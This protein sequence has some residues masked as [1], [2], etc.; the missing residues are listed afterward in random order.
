MFTAQVVKLI[1]LHLQRLSDDTFRPEIAAIARSI[2]H[3]STTDIELMGDPSDDR[4][5]PTHSPDASFICRGAGY[6]CVVIE[7]SFSQKRKDLP[8][9]AEDYI[10]GSCGNIRLVVGLDIE[11]RSSKRATVSVWESQEG[12]DE[13]GV[14]YLCAIKIVNDEV[15]FLVLASISAAVL[16][17][18]PLK[19]FR[20]DDSSPVMSNAALTLPL[21]AFT[22]PGTTLVRSLKDIV[23]SI[24]YRD[25]CSYLEDAERCQK[26]TKGP[27]RSDAMKMLQPGTR[28]R[29]S[30][31]TPESCFKPP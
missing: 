28:L 14:P 26:D 27:A 7:T 11:Y 31:R 24:P 30:Q 15:R 16:T 23:V 5:Y 2:A 6:P 19:L 3:L 29:R 12:F 13:D 4:I 8:D 20:N 9:L 25:L 18:K 17:P 21:S 22:P 10:I 1:E